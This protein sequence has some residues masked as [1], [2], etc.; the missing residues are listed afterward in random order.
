M[1]SPSLIGNYLGFY[2]F[3][4]IAGIPVA[5]FIFK[6]GYEILKDSIKVLPDASID[7]ESLNRIRGAV[8][9]I[10]GVRKIHSIKAR[11]S[12]KFIF[13]ELEVKTNL[14]DLERAY[15][16]CAK[17]ENEIK[18]KIKG[19]FYVLE[20]AYVDFEETGADTIGEVVD[21]IIQKVSTS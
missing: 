20:D 6:S 13:I 11:S 7:Y 9:E 1:N 3:D 2:Y 8:S 17:I 14:K 19:V 18:S 4:S 5:G 16:L 12:G 10:R 21:A 15:P